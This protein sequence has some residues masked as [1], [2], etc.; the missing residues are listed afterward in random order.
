MISE[1][2]K[3]ALCSTTFGIIESSSFQQVVSCGDDEE[4]SL[5]GFYETGVEGL[6][7]QKT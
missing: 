1:Q 7:F 3:E 6:T 4:A 2:I 5:M